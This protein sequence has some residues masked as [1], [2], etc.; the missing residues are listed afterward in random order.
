MCIT[1]WLVGHTVVS[2]SRQG[3]CLWGPTSEVFYRTAADAARAASLVV[4]P[5]YGRRRRP[6]KNCSLQSWCFNWK[7]ARVFYCPIKIH[8]SLVFVFVCA[9]VFCCFIVCFSSSSSF[10]LSFFLSWKYLLCVSNLLASN[11]KPMPTFNWERVNISET[12]I[13]VNT[14]PTDKLPSAQAHLCLLTV[15]S[16]ANIFP[17]QHSSSDILCRKTGS[18]CSS[19]SLRY[20]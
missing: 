6:R 13:H 17:P 12:P 5:L 18:S 15:R 8:V 19:L 2:V 14:T 20:R 3:L 10:F 4:C 7:L 1:L 11:S 9:F 16:V